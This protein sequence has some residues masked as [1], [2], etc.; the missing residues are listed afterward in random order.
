MTSPEICCI[1]TSY[2][3]FHDAPFIGG[4]TGVVGED[5]NFGVLKVKTAKAQLTKTPTLILFSID[6][7]SSM[8]E[9]TKSGLSKLNVVKQC[10]KNLALYLSKLDAPISIWAQTFDDEVRVIIDPL[11]IT[12]EYIDDVLARIASIKEDGSTN[13]EAALKSAHDIL[14]TYKRKNP[15]HEI[16][17]LFM[18]D[19][20][21]TAGDTKHNSL[22]KFME[23]ITWGNV[24]IGFGEDHNLALLKSLSEH[25]KS[26]YQFVNNLE[27][28]SSIYGEL[29]CPYLYPCIECCS[30]HA[31][32]GLIYDWKKNSWGTRI[33]EDIIVGGVEKIYHLRKA[34]NAQI[35]IDI[36]GVNRLRPDSVFRLIE[37]VD[38]IPHLLSFE[39]NDIVPTDLTKYLFRHETQRLLF[40]CCNCNQF[41]REDFKPVLRQLF[42]CIQK[43]RKDNNLLDDAFLQQLCDDLFITYNTSNS[44]TG[45]MFSLARYTSQ[46]RQQTNVATPTH[47]VP[48][49]RTPRHTRFND[50]V[51]SEEDDSATQVLQDNIDNYQ[52]N[53][54]TRSCYANQTVTDTMSQIQTQEY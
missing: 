50:N 20:Y 33:E 12:Q 46:G 47:F 15:G 21:P 41:E 38:P 22:S 30:I 10:F 49:L 28:T 29:L 53:L 48:E 24:F 2:F 35:I 31:E 14:T 51:C 23:D 17:H 6:T 36:Y 43:Y 7:S 34:V 13:I 4:I 45:A 9:L 11:Q 26:Y 37:N 5:E 40:E 18:T 3:E 8:S 27:D 44:S 19:G 39:T 32:G 52:P 16:V 25:P 42:D 1:D 54:R